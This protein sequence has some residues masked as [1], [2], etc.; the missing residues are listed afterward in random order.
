[1][2]VP[3]AV[4]VLSARD[5]GLL[6]S[7]LSMFGHAFGDLTTYTAQQP[8]DGYLEQLLGSPTFVSVA[9]VAEA[10]VVGG[11]AAYF[12]P[13]F[14]QARCELYIYDL[15]VEE[16]QRRNGIATALISKLREVA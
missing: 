2:N 12:L 10:Q 16:S 6:R 4:R 13:K 3:I 7:M 1:M 8:H 15:A 5:V 14:E 9:A 11:I